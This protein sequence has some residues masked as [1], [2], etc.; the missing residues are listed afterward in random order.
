MGS[1]EASASFIKTVERKERGNRHAEAEA[2]DPMLPLKKK[3]RGL[4]YGAKGQDPAKLFSA[5][6]KDN[7]GELDFDEF[8]AAVRKGGKL[9]LSKKELSALFDAIDDDDSGDISI[10]ELTVFVW[11]KDSPEARN[12]KAPERKSF[13]AA[14]LAANFATTVVRKER[15]TRHAEA[16]AADPLLPLKKKLR[17]LSYGA[18]GQ[19][20]AKLFSSFDKDNS[21][22]LDFD[23]FVSAIRKGGKLT[24]Q[25]ISQRKL[26]TLFDAIDDD[27]SG[28]VSIQELTAF[29]WSDDKPAAPAGPK[30]DEEETIVVIFRATVTFPPCPFRLCPLT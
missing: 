7:S 8:T 21:G 15:S 6:D 13:K 26:R 22:E 5:H 2:A 27:S 9:H 1:V 19:D 28:D 29:V 16:E 20:P 11:G 25:M 3:L 30:S 23:E 12:V 4:S 17:G 14:A 10:R 18:N 24:P